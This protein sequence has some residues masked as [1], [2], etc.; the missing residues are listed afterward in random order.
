MRLTTALAAIAFALV[1]AARAGSAAEPAPP[2]ESAGMEVRTYASSQDPALKLSAE[3][4][5]PDEAR[6]LCLCFHG[7]H[8]SAAVSRTS[9]PFVVP[10]TR[11]FFVVNVDMRG[12][13]GSSGTPDASGHEL[14]DGLDAL[15]YARKTWPSKVRAD[16]GPYLFGGS[17]G[18]GN[19]LALAGKAPDIFAAAVAYAG[20][21]DYALWY[22]DDKAGQYRDEMETRGWIGGNPTT[23]PEGYRSRGGIHVLPNVLA[24]LLVIHGTQDDSVPVHHAENYKK[25]AEE[26][27]KQ[28]IS[29]SL[30]KGGH[31]LPLEDI[32]KS[33]AF[34]NQ[35]A[36]PPKLPEKGKLLV[37]SFLACQRFWLILDHP[38]RVGTAEYETAADG[39]LR[40]LAFSQ[41]AGS[42][43]A[44][45]CILRL[46]GDVAA[47]S[48][49]AKGVQQTVQR[50]RQSGPYSDFKWTSDGPWTAR[51]PGAAAKP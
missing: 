5:V 44:K 29:F 18:G 49:E 30:W 43:P 24:H 3:F 31:S 23:N 15:E 7:W 25:K 26:L 14:I 12:R 33:V 28:N 9:E 46:S 6:P 8:Q 13:A 20:M 11:Q 39:A 19:V 36:Q 17:G 48:M 22:Q 41:P 51:L 42:T 40:S 32:P 16:A 2:K 10:L 35:H 1:I 34:L 37:H 45:E 50:W 47:V 21:S 27:Q 38:S 4:H